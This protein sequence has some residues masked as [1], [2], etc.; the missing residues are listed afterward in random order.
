MP[1]LI[2]IRHPRYPPVL[3]LIA[4]IKSSNRY[5]YP[6]LC[7]G[8]LNRVWND[9]RGVCGDVSRDESPRHC[10]HSLDTSCFAGCACSPHASCI[11]AP[12]HSRRWLPPRR[13]EQKST[14]LLLLYEL[15]IRRPRPQQVSPRDRARRLGWQDRSLRLVDRL[16]GHG[17]RRRGLGSRHTVL[18][19]RLVVGTRTGVA[20]RHMA[21]AGAARLGMEDRLVRTERGSEKMIV[22]SFERGTAAGLLQHNWER[23]DRDCVLARGRIEELADS[24]LELEDIETGGFGNC[25]FADGRCSSRYS[26]CLLW[27]SRGELLMKIGV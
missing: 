18:G 26:T 12:P 6:A 16:D 23:Q 27:T 5:H 17:S 4:P 21:A 10:P 15:E 11:R 9:F 1:T 20:E 19:R 13:R 7:S 22:G 25:G 3:A 14:L 24:R 8:S 2:S